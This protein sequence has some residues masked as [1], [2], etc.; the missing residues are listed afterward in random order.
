[1][2]EFVSLTELVGIFPAA[3]VG[4][5]LDGKFGGSDALPL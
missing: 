2:F 4:G 1:M 5:V 3:V